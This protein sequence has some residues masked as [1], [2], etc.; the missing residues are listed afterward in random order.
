MRRSTHESLWWLWLWYFVTGTAAFFITW[1]IFYV[2]P[3]RWILPSQTKY[4]LSTDLEV[5][6]NPAVTITVGTFEN[7]SHHWELSLNDFQRISFLAVLLVSNSVWIIAECRF[8]FSLDI[9]YRSKSN[10]YQN[11]RKNDHWCSWHSVLCNL[12][13]GYDSEK[14]N[15]S[16]MT[17]EIR[18]IHCGCLVNFN[19]STKIFCS[20]KSKSSRVTH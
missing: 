17:E 4:W 8:F 20:A 13:L 16:K 19:Y 6:C 1:G 3:P 10:I 5:L 18:L 7:I 12:L 11:E 14:G 9:I 2:R 15:L